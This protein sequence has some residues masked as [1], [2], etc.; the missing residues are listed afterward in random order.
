MSTQPSDT[1]WE[2][3]C[4]S[5]LGMVYEAQGD[6]L[7]ALNFMEQAFAILQA[8]NSKMLA[9]SIEQKINELRRK[10][11]DEDKGEMF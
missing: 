1:L 9:Q 4:L 10:L 3:I 6:L 7:K 2:G 5:G 8:P 11:D